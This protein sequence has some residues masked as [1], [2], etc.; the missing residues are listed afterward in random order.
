MQI[1]RSGAR[2]TGMDG[3]RTLYS[4]NSHDTESFGRVAKISFEPK[5]NEMFFADG[6]L[7]KRVAVID[8]TTGDFKRYWGAYGEAPDDEADLGRYSPDAPPARQ[9][10]GV[11]LL[12]SH[13]EPVSVIQP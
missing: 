1:G 5:A 3:G 9:F 10:R 7:N 11:R 2:A 13:K 6:Y 4:G 8:A 12:V